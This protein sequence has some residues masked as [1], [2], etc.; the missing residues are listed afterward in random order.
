MQEEGGMYREM[1]VT[2]NARRRTALPPML[3]R[4][5]MQYLRNALRIIWREKESVL[6]GRRFEILE[7]AGAVGSG[8]RNFADDG[9]LCFKLFKLFV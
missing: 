4:T 7:G 5:D 6:L 1:Q 8:G 9:G 2:A 3:L